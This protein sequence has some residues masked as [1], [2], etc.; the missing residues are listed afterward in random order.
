MKVQLILSHVRVALRAEERIAKNQRENWEFFVR[1]CEAVYYIEK[2]VSKVQYLFK[3]KDME[4]SFNEEIFKDLAGNY[5][6]NNNA[7][8]KH[9]KFVILEKKK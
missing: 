1:G 9:K 4:I 7:N 8:K 5:I 3:I 2:S 6:V